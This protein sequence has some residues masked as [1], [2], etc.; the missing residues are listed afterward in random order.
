MIWNPAAPQDPDERISMG[1][2]ITLNPVGGTMYQDADGGG[3]Q[4]GE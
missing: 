1:T 3:S 2:D 4:T